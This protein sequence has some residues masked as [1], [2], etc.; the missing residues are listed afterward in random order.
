MTG[1]DPGALLVVDLQNAFC[2][3][4]GSSARRGRAA[5]PTAAV[6]GPC[7]RLAA[8]AR[9]LSVPV[10]LARYAYQAGYSDGGVL[11]SQVQQSIAAAG[12][13]LDGSWDA[14]LVAELRPAPGDILVVKN[15][16]SAFHQ[17]GLAGLLRARGV[18]SVAVCGVTTR[19]CVEG[20]AR[21]A[22]QHDFAVTVIEDACAEYEPAD[23]DQ[24]LRLIR[25]AIGSVCPAAEV[26]SAWAARR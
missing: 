24:A 13:L 15:R 2:H 18:A 7:V 16:Y 10:V 3:P 14:E 4:A 6:I 11:I 19:V 21:D 1:A 9:A 12:G 22:V 26:I 5:G 8:A 20:S 25:T 23:H 17:T